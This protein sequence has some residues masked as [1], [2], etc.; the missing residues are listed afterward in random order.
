MLMMPRSPEKKQNIFNSKFSA[1]YHQ[2]Y[3]IQSSMHVQHQCGVYSNPALH[4][5]KAIFATLFP[6]AYIN[7][8]Q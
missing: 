5:T 4:S 7:W 2:V 6:R 8:I 3:H 1:P